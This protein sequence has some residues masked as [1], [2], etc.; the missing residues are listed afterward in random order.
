MAG[1]LTRDS[2]DRSSVIHSCGCDVLLIE[3]RAPLLRIIDSKSLSSLEDEGIRSLRNVAI[4]VKRDAALYCRWTEPLT[5][6][7]YCLQTH[8][9]VISHKHTPYQWKYLSQDNINIIIY[10]LSGY[11][12]EDWVNNHNN[13]YDHNHHYH[14]RNVVQRLVTAL[15]LGILVFHSLYY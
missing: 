6:S 12:L 4:R 10:Y 2:V 8:E 9:N 15:S 13:Y 11:N 5:T 1:W 14:S 3:L 7:A